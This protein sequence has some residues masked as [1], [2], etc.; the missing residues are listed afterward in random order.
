MD[1]IIDREV[2]SKFLDDAYKCKPDNLGH[3]L[4]KIEYEIQNRD[5]ADSILLRAKTVVTSKIALIN[6]K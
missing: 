1:E 6:S 2:S 5:H 4:Q 3:L